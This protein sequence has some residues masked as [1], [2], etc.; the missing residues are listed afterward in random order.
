MHQIRQHLAGAGYPILGDDK[1]GDF[2]L[3][4]VLSKELRL[5][6]LMLY[7]WMLNLP[8]ADGRQLVV[9][10]GLPPHFADFFLKT[11]MGNQDAGNQDG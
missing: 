7:A 1:H 11:G 10:A 4:K 3:N 9:K 8:M 5:K 6:R 2:R